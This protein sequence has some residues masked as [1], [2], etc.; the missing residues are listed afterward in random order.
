MCS[1]ICFKLDQSRILSSGSG[2]N[3]ETERFLAV[4]VRKKWV[5]F[6]ILTI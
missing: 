5:S 6:E 2:L 1:A 3:D 4:E